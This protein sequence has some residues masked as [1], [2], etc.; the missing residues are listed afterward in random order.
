[1]GLRNPWPI[2]SCTKAI[3]APQQ[4]RD[5]RSSRLYLAAGS[6]LF[7]WHHGRHYAQR[8]QRRAINSAFT[9]PTVYVL[10]R[11]R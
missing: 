1:M 6:A 10:R 2:A 5:W 8:P 7:E 9:Q 3:R 11:P 4:T